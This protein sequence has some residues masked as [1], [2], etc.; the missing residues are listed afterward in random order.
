MSA[1]RVGEHKLPYQFDS[2]SRG[3]GE[4]PNAFLAR[5]IGVWVVWAE[6][7]S[8]RCPNFMFATAFLTVVTVFVQSEA[9]VARTHVRA[10]G[11]TTFLLTA[12]VVDGALV[13]V[14]EVNGGEACLL[15]RV[16]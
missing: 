1:T 3:C 9:V 6:N 16:I 8:V 2:M 11:V 5:R 4:M 12:A 14:G 15:H 10:D 13:L 7:V